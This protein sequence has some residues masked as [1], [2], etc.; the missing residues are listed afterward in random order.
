MA[1]DRFCFI[2]QPY[3]LH[4]LLSSSSS[5]RGTPQEGVE[6]VEEDDMLDW[7]LPDDDISVP[8][9][10]LPPYQDESD[11]TLLPSQTHPS[12]PYGNPY[13]SL[14]LL[15][16]STSVTA[17]SS[18]PHPV[19]STHSAPLSTSLT[20]LELP[21]LFALTSF[22]QPSERVWTE[23]ALTGLFGPRTKREIEEDEEEM[24]RNVN[25]HGDAGPPA[26][27]NAADGAEDETSDEEEG[28]GTDRGS[29]EGD[30]TGA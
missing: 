16:S 3:S 21:S 8:L 4:S 24:E 13:Q 18:R 15:S 22:G 30:R 20:S 29:V 11:E 28:E 27:Q 2:H 10:L 12:Y 1:D 9:H 23:S 6:H 19:G 17:P 14:S 25:T 7:T 26:G 5:S